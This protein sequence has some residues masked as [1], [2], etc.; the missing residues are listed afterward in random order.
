MTFSPGAER[1]VTGRP[2]VPV[3]RTQ[4]VSLY[5]PPPT[6]TVSP[7]LAFAA[8]AQIVLSAVWELL[9]PALSSPSVATSHVKGGRRAFAAPHEIS[10]ASLARW[11]SITSL[12]SR[13]P[14]SNV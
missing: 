7:T 9:P 12:G 3:L 13:N 10:A 14:W 5:V 8:A 4:T 11:P 6:I 1:K 2:A